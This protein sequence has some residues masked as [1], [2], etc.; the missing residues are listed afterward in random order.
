MN[1][2]RQ[3]HG[4]RVSPREHGLLLLVRHAAD[5]YSRICPY[6]G[7]PVNL[8]LPSDSDEVV[9]GVPGPPGRSFLP[10]FQILS[11]TSSF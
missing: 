4:H 6:L 1:P 7:G 8:G 3:G 5:S 11:H 10:S 2:Y 9:H